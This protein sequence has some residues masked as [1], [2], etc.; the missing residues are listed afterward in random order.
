MFAVLFH[1]S[2]DPFYQNISSFPTV[3][4]TFFLI[5]MILYWVVAVIGLVDVDIL[6]IDVD[7]LDA[8]DSIGNENAI[9]GLLLKFG[10]HG[11]P[12][13]IVV[14]LLALIGWLISYYLVHFLISWLPTGFMRYIAGLPILLVSL[15]VATL[16]TAQIIKPVRNLFK[17]ADQEPV[18]HIIGQVAVVRSSRADNNFGEAMM[19]DGG[20]GLILKIRTTGDQV[21]NKGDRVVIFEHLVPENAYRVISEQEFAEGTK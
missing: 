11:V 6:D 9:A 20:A 5:V 3:F 2:M 19:A 8:N 7:G 10:L 1:K 14:S 12:V 15:Y 21:F 17:K 13:T 18:I 16:I 4:F